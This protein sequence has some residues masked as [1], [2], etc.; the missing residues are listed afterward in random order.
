LGPWSTEPLPDHALLFGLV[1]DFAVNHH[2]AAVTSMRALNEHLVAAV[3]FG[4]S[5][6]INDGYLL[7]HKV[8][9][10]AVLKPDSSPLCQLVES[11]F[12]KILTRN[13]RALGDLAD[14]M[15]EEDIQSARQLRSTD[16]YVKRLQPAL[17]RWAEKLRLVEEGDASFSSWPAAHV[18]QIFKRLTTT[19]L[20]A[21]IDRTDQDKHR[22]ELQEFQAVWASAS[23]SANR[24]DWEREADLRRGKHKQLSEEVHVALMRIANEAYQYAWGCA[25]SET[26]ARVTVETRAPMYLDL[27]VS[28]GELDPARPPKGVTVYGPDI[29]VALSGPVANG[30]CW[31]RS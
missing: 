30:R 25:L 14:H 6:L 28:L 16:A 21:A 2:D 9:Q 7:N 23:K 1:D 12:V 15:A 8:L 22:K 4:D 26:D 18:S 31:R 3:L 11:G 24:T 17:S 13:E 20:K 19:A 27:D 10:E 29:A 5:L